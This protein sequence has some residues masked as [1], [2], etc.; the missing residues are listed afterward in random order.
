VQ[1]REHKKWIPV[2]RGLE[3]KI[4]HGY[5]ITRQRS[6]EQ[7]QEGKSWEDGRIQERGYFASRVGPWHNEDKERLGT[8][9]L[10]AALSQM[11]EGMI[12]ER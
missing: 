10:V 4:K 11:L 7:V 2:L 5:Y 8:E 3:H 1:P 9:K 6:T 12:S